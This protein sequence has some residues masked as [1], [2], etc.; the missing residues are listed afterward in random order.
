VN[1][2]HWIRIKHFRSCWNF[3]QN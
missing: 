1:L 3:H 2:F